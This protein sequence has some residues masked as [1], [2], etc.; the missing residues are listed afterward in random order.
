MYKYEDER[1][2]IFTEDGQR[3]FIKVRDNVNNLLKTAGA[4]KMYPALNCINGDSWM[5]MA[6]IDRL[7]ELGE[8]KEVTA[9]Y[10]WGQD[11]VFV[12]K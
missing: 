7:V 11:R 10:T 8:I 9:G 2:K 12:R 3:D 4:F 5:A 6:Y 1:E